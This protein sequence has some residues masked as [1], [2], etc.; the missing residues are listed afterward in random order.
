MKTKPC[1]IRQVQDSKPFVEKLFNEKV[2][3]TKY[4]HLLYHRYLILHRVQ[5]N[6]KKK[7]VITTENNRFYRVSNFNTLEKNKRQFTE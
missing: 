2:G 1:K 4:A 6:E 7:T 5:K 3:V